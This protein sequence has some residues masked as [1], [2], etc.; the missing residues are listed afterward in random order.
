MYSYRTE[1][2][3]LKAYEDARRVY[4]A[5]GVDTEAA[6]ARARR[7]AVSL[8]CWQGD[9]VTGLEATRTGGDMVVT[10]S[11]PGRARNGDE[12]RADMD[13]ALSLS[14]LAPRVNLHSM[15]AEPG[16]TERN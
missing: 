3:V 11:Y 12:L 15:Y 4:R 9:D 5:F 1:D 10:G 8:Q 14:P 13:L 7:A 6:I 2:S 16:T